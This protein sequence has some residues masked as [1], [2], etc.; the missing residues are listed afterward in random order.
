MA[1]ANF[2]QEMHAIG[3]RLLL[4]LQRLPQAEP[5]EI[6]AFSVIVIFTGWAFAFSPPPLCFLCSALS[7]LSSH[8]CALAAD[9]RQLLLR[10]VLL[11]CTE[12]QEGPGGPHDPTVRDRA[13]TEET[14]KATTQGVSLALQPSPLKTKI[15]GPSSGLAQEPGH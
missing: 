1:A 10:S 15:Q 12:R 3:E 5:V 13:T 11:P 14:A 9:S 8:R 7:Q 6:V 2:V 4:R